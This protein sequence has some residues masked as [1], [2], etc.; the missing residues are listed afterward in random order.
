MSEVGQLLSVLYYVEM[1]TIAK[2]ILSAHKDFNHELCQRMHPL[3][4]NEDSDA[5]VEMGTAKTSHA[6]APKMRYYPN[7]VMN[8]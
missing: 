1:S 3:V 5:T 7:H 4:E 6:V 8:S 2:P